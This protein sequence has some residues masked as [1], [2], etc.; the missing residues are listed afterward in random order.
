MGLETKK[1]LKLY[2][3]AVKGGVI[4]RINGIRAFVPASQLSNRYVEDLSTFV[5]NFTS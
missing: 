5:S 3:L 2:V 4:A 1:N